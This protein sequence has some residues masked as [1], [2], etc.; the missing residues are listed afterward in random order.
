VQS[1]GVAYKV[2]PRK[3]GSTPTSRS[4]FKGE[5][6]YRYTANKKVV[7]GLLLARKKGG[8]ALNAYANNFSFINDYSLYILFVM[9]YENTVF[10]SKNKRQF[11][12]V[13]GVLFPVE[14]FDCEVV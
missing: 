9:K 2:K 4:R 12:P 10:Y 8:N 14:F 11:I 13:E 7:K 6:M 5:G 3:V 1:T